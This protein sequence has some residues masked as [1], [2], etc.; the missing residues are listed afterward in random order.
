MEKS[1]VEGGFRKKVDQKQPTYLQNENRS[2][3]EIYASIRGRFDSL[4]TYLVIQDEITL[5]RCHPSKV[6]RL[7]LR[8]Q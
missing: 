5:M 2:R 7:A 3:E 8:K 1:A 6:A 4:H